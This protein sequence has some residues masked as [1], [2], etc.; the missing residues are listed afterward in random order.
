MPTVAA[1]LA[2]LATRAPGDKAAAWDPH[3]L[4]IGDS[5]AVVTR[6]AVCHEVTDLVADR[7]VAQKVELLLSYHPLLFEAAN[8]WLAGAGPSGRAYRLI[9]AG[10]GVAVAHTGWDAA[11]GGTADALAASFDLTGVSGFGAIDPPVKTKLVAFVPSSSVDGVTAALFG[12]GAGRIGNYGGCSFRSEGTGTFFAEEGAR[13]AAGLTGRFNQEAEVRLEVVMDKGVEG[14]AI[15]ALLDAHPYE[16]PAFDLYEVRSNLGQIGRVGNLEP[17]VTLREF[18]ARVEAVLGAPVRCSGDRDRKV[19]RVAVLPGSGGTYIGQAA[20]GGADVY[21]TGDLSHHETR[22][23]LDRG[24]ST[25]D[26]G[27]A[28]TERP[29]VAR[30]LAVAREIMLDAIDLTSDPTPW[31]EG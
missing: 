27:H 2:D 28:A 11:R 10:V 15:A 13:P 31:L 8:R 29:G 16:E 14:R 7:A 19:S 26:P 6:L 4:Q 1:L 22:E 30:L 17:P 12:V 3:G 21:V 20:A 5:E 25:I 18:A 9:R 23:S 24:V